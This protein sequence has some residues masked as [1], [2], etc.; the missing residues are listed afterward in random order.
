MAT[1]SWSTHACSKGVMSVS[2]C[3]EMIRQMTQSGI[4]NLSLLIITWDLAYCRSYQHVIAFTNSLSLLL[5]VQRVKSSVDAFSVACSLLHRCHYPAIRHQ[6]GICIP[7]EP[8]Q[9]RTHGE[10]RSRHAFQHLL[11][12]L[13]K[14]EGSVDIFETSVTTL[15]SLEWLATGKS[16]RSRSH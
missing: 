5:D 2:V 9:C 4:G 6:D 13:S 16:W 8:P 14:S 10:W 3:R 12:V 11:P 15:C 7:Q 1:H